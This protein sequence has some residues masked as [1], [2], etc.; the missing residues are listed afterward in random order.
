MD[1]LVEE[2]NCALRSRGYSAVEA[3]VYPDQRYADLAVLRGSLVSETFD[4]KG[5]MLLLVSQF[6][7]RDD[8]VAIADQGADASASTR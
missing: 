3:A 5:Q 1:V 7:E 6:P 8:L 4:Q 2:A